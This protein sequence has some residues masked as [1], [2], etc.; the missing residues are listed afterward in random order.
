MNPSP[1]KNKYME[2]QYKPKKLL[3]AEKEYAEKIKNATTCTKSLRFVCTKSKSENWP[4][5]V[6][7]CGARWSGGA[8]HSFE[9]ERSSG[10][11]SIGSINGNGIRNRSASVV[12]AAPMIVQEGI[13]MLLISV[14]RAQTQKQVQKLVPRPSMPL[15]DGHSSGQT[16]GQTYL[17]I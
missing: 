1:H 14:H 17:S 12:A 15:L 7:F 10:N 2:F 8:T 16:N 11:S 13:P 3:H 5:M 4:S 9:K 6:R